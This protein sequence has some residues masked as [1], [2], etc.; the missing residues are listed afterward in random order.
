MTAEIAFFNPVYMERIAQLTN[1]TNQFN[2]TTRRYTL[3]ELESAASDGKHICIYGKLS[4]RFGDNGLILRGSR[5]RRG[6][7]TAY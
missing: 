1:K 6:K 5:H 7:R 2:L 3:V 4:D